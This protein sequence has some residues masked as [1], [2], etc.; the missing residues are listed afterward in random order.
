MPVTKTPSAPPVSISHPRAIHES[1]A[2]DP[3]IPP[4]EPCAAG[5]IAPAFAGAPLAG[6]LDHVGQLVAEPFRLLP[7][8][9]IPYRPGIA[10]HRRPAFQKPHLPPAA[11]LLLTLTL[12]AGSAGTLLIQFHH[13][14]PSMT[15]RM[16]SISASPKIPVAPIGTACLGNSK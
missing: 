11:L 16:A 1:P 15:C 9:L 3:L 14:S 4:L 5:G 13:K 8:H 7:P 6:A 10:V 2:T 12:P